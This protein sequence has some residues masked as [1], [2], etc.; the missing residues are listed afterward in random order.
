MATASIENKWKI[1]NF[2]LQFDALFL[3]HMNVSTLIPHVAV[4]HIE[5]VITMRKIIVDDIK[6]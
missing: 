4:V 5:S 1:L 3:F 6:I 2:I